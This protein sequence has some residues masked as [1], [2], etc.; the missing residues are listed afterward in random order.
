MCLPTAQG[1]EFEIDD[2]NA[3]SFVR[4][5]PTCFGGRAQ[6]RISNVPG[7]YREARC[8]CYFFPSLQERDF[9]DSS[10]A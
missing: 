2:V 5:E 9:M 8:F 1:T 10:L 7:T 6:N 4:V 3:K